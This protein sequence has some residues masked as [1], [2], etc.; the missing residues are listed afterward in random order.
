[1]NE[2]IKVGDQVRIAFSDTE[3][4]TGT[5]LYIPCATGD[6]WHIRVSDSVD[7]L[8]YVQSFETMQRLSTEAKP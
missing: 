2:T 1:M 4:M 5:V 3:I 8:F 7:G 6:S